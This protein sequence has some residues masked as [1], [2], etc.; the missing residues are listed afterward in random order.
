MLPVSAAA[1]AVRR[2]QR[3][4]RGP[5]PQCAPQATRLPAAGCRAGFPAPFQRPSRLFFPCFPSGFMSSGVKGRVA[6][7]RRASSP[8]VVRTGRVSACRSG[9]APHPHPCRRLVAAVSAVSCAIFLRFALHFGIL[10]GVVAVA[11]VRLS[12]APPHAP[13]QPRKA[14][15][16]CP[17]CS[18]FPP[19]VPVAE[20][21][22]LVLCGGLFLSVQTSAGAHGY[23]GD[24]GTD[25]GW[26]CA[27]RRL[28]MAAEQPLQRRD[29]V[30]CTA[31]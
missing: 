27:R 11:P 10:R 19:R 4:P 2:P 13:P 20:C 17:A 30:V 22:F 18:S 15:P 8:S 1:A 31:L 21:G 16:S 26:N 28:K 5:E 29:A 9:S 6:Q 25:S 7:V 14:R 3:P 12:A 24:N 23:H